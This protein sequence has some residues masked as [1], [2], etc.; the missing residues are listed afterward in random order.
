MTRR[1]AANL[2]VDFT[3]P[4]RSSAAKPAPDGRHRM[5]GPR[6]WPI[7]SRP[8]SSRE[9]YANGQHLLVG[10]ILQVLESMIAPSRSNGTPARTVVRVARLSI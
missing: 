7:H 4:L 8:Y 9:M 2:N 6:P 5:L 1:L 3:A 10:L